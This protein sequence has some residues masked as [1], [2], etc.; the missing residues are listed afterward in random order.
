MLRIRDAT[1][2]TV[3]DDGGLVLQT[4]TGE[5]NSIKVSL[6]EPFSGALVLLASSSLNPMARIT[7][8]P[9]IQFCV[10]G[11]TTM[12]TE[13]FSQLLSLKMLGRGI[14]KLLLNVVSH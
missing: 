3:L 11:Q 4:K 13:R 9:V 10:R 7:K 8:E 1:E 6:S 12:S 2:G 14:M 5:I